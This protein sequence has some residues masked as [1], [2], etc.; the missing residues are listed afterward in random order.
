[1]SDNQGMT[2]TVLG[3]P[4]AQPRPRFWKGR[5]ISTAS[6]SHQL[7]KGAVTREAQQAAKMF[8]KETWWQSGALEVRIYYSFPT[9]D[10]RKWGEPKVTKPDVDNLNKLTYD[11]LEAGGLLPGGD[12]RI[13]TER[14]AKVWAEHGR[15]IIE[16]RP[17]ART[18]HHSLR[19]RGSYWDY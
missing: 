8:A 14:S 10:R 2:L 18:Q 4:L 19:A 1:M 17:L 7:W 5:V 11:A 9:K 12:Q 15:V 6:K 3:K 13:A 16:I